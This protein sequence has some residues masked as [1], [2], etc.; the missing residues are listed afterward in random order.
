MNMEQVI[1]TPVI[2][3]GVYLKA[4]LEAFDQWL[5]RDEVT[6]ILVNRPGEV[7]IEA[8]GVAGMTRLDA[9]QVDDRLLERLAQQIARESH[10]GI[11]RERPVLSATLRAG[12]NHRAA[13]HAQALGFGDP[14]PSP[15][16]C[17][18]FCL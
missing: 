4:H 1:E 7:W 16:R 15:R 6:E 14:A 2:E 10:Q 11:N 8:S 18:A 13:R 5:A 9:P 3:S 12:A 17:A